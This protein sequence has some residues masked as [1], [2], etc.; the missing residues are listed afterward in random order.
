MM[1]SSGQIVKTITGRD[2]TPFP[3]VKVDTNRKCINTINTIKKVDQW[4]FDNA[5]LEAE[6]RNDE[7]VLLQF[8]CAKS[9]NLT[10]S[11]KDSMHL[12][13]FGNIV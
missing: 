5:I 9:N 11:D 2:T 4:L 3:T 12:Y 1:L 13:L 10:Q 8:N 7:F 6:S